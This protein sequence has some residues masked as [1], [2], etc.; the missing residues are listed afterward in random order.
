MR[1]ITVVVQASMPHQTWVEQ[2]EGSEDTQVK[3]PHFSNFPASV[4]R[5]GVCSDC[6]HLAPLSVLLVVHATH[7]GVD[8]L[9]STCRIA[10]QLHD[11]QHW[12]TRP[13]RHLSDEARRMALILEHQLPPKTNSAASFD[14]LQELRPAPFAISLSLCYTISCQVRLAM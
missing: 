6:T 7:G 10:Q 3:T 9:P 1:I 12:N 13:Y 5:F 4:W 2:Y 8:T 11:E 14:Q